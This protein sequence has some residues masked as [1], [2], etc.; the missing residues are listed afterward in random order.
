MYQGLFS[1]LGLKKK[2]SI[3]INVETP[4]WK[5]CLTF[6]SICPKSLIY[7]NNLQKVALSAKNCSDTL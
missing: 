3:P 2:F 4:E 7:E 1:G 6:L 5:F